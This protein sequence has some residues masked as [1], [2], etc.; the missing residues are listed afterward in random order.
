MTRGILRSSAGQAWLELPLN[1]TTPP[2]HS[3][4][5]QSNTAQRLEGSRTVG[6]LNG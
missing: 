3:G 5:Y 4:K 1:L 2:L 6:S